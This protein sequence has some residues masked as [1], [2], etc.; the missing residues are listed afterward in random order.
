MCFCPG[1]HL[2]RQICPKYRRRPQYPAHHRRFDR[3][4]R[5]HGQSPPARGVRSPRHRP[6]GS[7]INRETDERAGFHFLQPRQ[8][9]GIQRVTRRHHINHL[10]ADHALH[11][12]RAAPAPQP[13][14]GA[15]SRCCAWL[16]RSIFQ[17][18]GLSAH[19]PPVS[20]SPRQRPCAGPACRAAYH[21]HPCRADRHGSAN[22]N[23]YTQSRSPPEW[24]RVPVRRKFAQMPDIKK[25]ETLAVGKNRVAHGF[26]RR[27][28]CPS[29][30]A[31]NASS[32]V[33]TCPAAC[34][35]SF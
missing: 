20:R 14:Q 18:Q 31:K 19:R 25:G 3:P 34:C 35:N 10:P 7:G 1:R 15:W 26:M 6:N 32:A 17:R 8:A 29:G 16:H 27:P 9:T 2:C 4:A 33:F 28:S 11:A 23:E 22:S 30:T 21:H 24:R 5:Y 13:D 12:R